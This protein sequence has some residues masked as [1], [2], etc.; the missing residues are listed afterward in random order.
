VALESEDVLVG[1]GAGVAREEIAGE[2]H[3][4]EVVSGAEVTDLEKVQSLGRILR[5]GVEKVEE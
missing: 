1:R 2:V 4:V 3:G 5:V